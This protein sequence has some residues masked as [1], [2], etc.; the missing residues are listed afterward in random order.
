[1][2][3]GISATKETYPESND[4]FASNGS[5]AR[6]HPVGRQPK[7]CIEAKTVAAATAGVIRKTFPELNKKF[8][9]LPDPRRQDMCRYSGKHIWWSG[10]LM[11]LTRAGSRNAF[12]QARNSGT[13]PEN[14]GCFCGQTSDDFRFD[15]QPLITCS[16]N[17]THHLNRVDATYSQDIPAEMCQELLTKRMFDGARILDS[18]YILVFDGTVQERC[19]QG[20]EDGGK[21][22]RGGARYRYVLQCGVLGPGQ[23]IFPMMH[24]HVDMHNPEIEKEDCE[25]KAFFRLTGRLKKKFPRLR[26]CIV[27]DA[28]Y[29][30]EPVADICVR[31]DWKYVLTLKE[32]RQ[33]CLW[34]ELLELLPF[35]SGNRLRVWTGQDGTAGLRDFRWVEDLPLGKHKI[36]AVLS[37]EFVGSEGTLYAYATNLLVNRDRVLAIIAS[38]GRERH[39]IEDYFNAGKNHGIGL[40]HVFCASSNASK[41]FYTLMQVAA[42]LWTIACHGFLMRTFGWA[43]H[44]TETA[45]ARAIAEGMRAGLFPQQL[46]APGQLRFVT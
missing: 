34:D 28:L 20:F 33:P 22:G 24:E 21:N 29:C 13:M 17:L 31:Y 14:M 40:E 27:G 32:G 30:A 36:T 19:R 6:R 18:W 43:A 10:V 8:A 4:A 1:M 25:L 5:K 45:L 41:N 26:F 11:F 12:D 2:E 46:P 23:T 38:S 7:P 37:G 16:D 15:G 9:G 39:R 42:I 35:S 3:S 44:A